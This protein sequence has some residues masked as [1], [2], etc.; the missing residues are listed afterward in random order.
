VAIVDVTRTA[1]ASGGSGRE[2]RWND[3]Q[4]VD[5]VETDDGGQAPGVT[6]SGLDAF[7]NEW[8]IAASFRHAKGHRPRPEPNPGK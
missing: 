7:I 5:M 6:Y 1:V 4:V 2:A 3:L 8:L